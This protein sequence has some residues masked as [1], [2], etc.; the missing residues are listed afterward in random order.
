MTSA[1]AAAA[2]ARIL[3]WSKGKRGPPFD[4]ALL[5]F[6]LTAR[7]ELERTAVVKKR[8]DRSPLR[9]PHSCALH[10]LQVRRRGRSADARRQQF[11]CALVARVG[12]QG[13]VIVAKYRIATCPAKSYHG[14]DSHLP[15][16]RVM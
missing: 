8:V 7:A 3:L 4:R 16:N 6:S 1:S 15:A 5:G 2:S 12:V 13:W 11:R 10:C 9:R 14:G